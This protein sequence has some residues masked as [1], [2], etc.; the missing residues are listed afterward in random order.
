M[1]ACAIMEKCLNPAKE[2]IGL[3]T[4]FDKGPSI[5]TGFQ[6]KMLVRGIEKALDCT[7]EI[8][9]IQFSDEFFPYPCLGEMLFWAVAD[10]NGVVTKLERANNLEEENNPIK[11][12]FVIGTYRMF[13]VK[14]TDQ[15][16]R[17]GEI[18]SVSGNTVTFTRYDK[19]AAE[20]KIHHSVYGGAVPKP[21]DGVSF[22]LSPNVILYKWDWTNALAP[23]SRCSREEAAAKKFVTKATIGT[24]EDIKKNCYWLGFYS[25]SGTDECDLIKCFLNAPPGWE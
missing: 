3:I 4:G 18:L 23:F 20:G 24:L 15:T 5:R 1:E 21:A 22:T 6:M 19:F 2:N 16:P 14:I 17:I 12:Y 10:K 13:V 11:T 25:I 7:E 8:Y 9:N